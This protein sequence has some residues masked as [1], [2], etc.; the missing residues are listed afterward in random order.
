[1]SPRFLIALLALV[2]GLLISV[3]FLRTPEEP[4]TVEKKEKPTFQ[5]DHDFVS[6]NPKSDR[7]VA[8]K[9]DRDLNFDRDAI[10]YE[11]IIAFK[12]PED[13]QRFLKRLGNSKLRNLGKIG[14]L[15]AVRVGFDDYSLF[16][17]LGLDPDDLQFNFPVTLPENETSIAP[18]AGLASFG[19]SMLDFI[20]VT[21]DNSAWGEGVRVAVIDS[22][23]QPHIALDPDILRI[24]LVGLEAGVEPDSHG[25]SVASLIA[26][27]HP[28][29]TGVA[30][31]AEIISVQVIDE[32]GTSSSFLLAEGIVA[33][34]DARA[35]LIN[36]SLGSSGDSAL[37]RRAVDYATENGSVIFAS[38]GNSG[39]EQAAF[40]A[41]YPDVFAVGAVDANGTY[42]NFSNTDD[43]LALG[44]PGYEVL[45]AFPGDNA[46]SFTGTSASSPIAVGAAAALISELDITATAAVNILLNHANEA[47]TPGADPEFGQG[48]VDLGRALNHDTPGIIDAAVASQTFLFPNEA[49]GDVG[50]VQVAIENRG[51]EPIFQAQV[52]IGIDGVDFPTNIQQIQ[53]NEV[54]VISIPTGLQSLELQGQ[55][56]LR[57]EVTLSNGASDIQPGNDGRSD[58]ITLPNDDS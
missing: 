42:V 5:A 58:V 50:G 44:A 37:V 25:T 39:A 22:G 45:A 16:E 24:D 41:G 7:K 52:Q 4:E 1:M 19:N 3:I 12:N 14:A 33:A 15:N 47:G 26:G 56:N 54:R 38:S 21:G 40:P 9:S 30:P 20:G 49:T 31:S 36:I 27:N 35:E 2:V 43:N 55:L 13:Y 32:T 53:P 17:T 34:V 23:V 10:P 57:S 8:Q 48:I 29:L 28:N 18:Q 51:T 6:A 46:I 11:R